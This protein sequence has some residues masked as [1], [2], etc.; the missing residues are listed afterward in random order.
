MGNSRPPV[1]AAQQIFIP[2]HF[3]PEKTPILTRMILEHPTEKPQQVPWKKHSVSYTPRKPKKKQNKNEEL[4]K[5]L[6]TH[7]SWVR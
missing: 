6:C 2:R 3:F 7:L 4:E 1:L 5:G